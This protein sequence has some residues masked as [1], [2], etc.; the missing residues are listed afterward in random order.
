MADEL[1]PEPP[2]FAPY[3]RPAGGWGALHGTA[4]AKRRAQRLEDTAIDE[5]TR[6]L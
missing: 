4:R 2:V 6:R 1:A 5:P 3:N